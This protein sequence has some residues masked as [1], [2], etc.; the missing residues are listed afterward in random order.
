MN[1]RE[2][3]AGAACLLAGA[4]LAFP[5]AAFAQAKKPENGTDYLTLGKTVAG[6]RAA[7]QGRGDRILLVQLPALQ[8]LRAASSTPGSRS[9]R[10]TWSSSACRWPSA[11]TSCRSSACY[12][13]LEA[14]GKVDELHAKVFQAIHAERQPINREDLILAWVGKQGLDTAKFKELYNSFS[15]ASKARARHPAAG[16]T[17][18]CRACRPSASPAATTSTA[19]WPA[20]MDRALQVTDYLIAEARKALSCA[21]G[22]PR[23]P[24]LLCPKSPLRRAFS[25]GLATMPARFMPVAYNRH[26]QVSCLYE[27]QLLC[28]PPPSAVAAVLALA[29]VGRGG[30]P[31]PR[32]PT[33]TSR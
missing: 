31:R 24:R 9:C 16:R 20:S 29:L 18:R 14:M 5:G 30:W 15:V 32:R 17:T 33:G 8:R 11:T 21:G 25:A 10:Q 4:A 7:R 26:E 19:T 1:R 13:T 22:R 6:R 27:I 2:F 3:S 12:Y 28:L 23:P